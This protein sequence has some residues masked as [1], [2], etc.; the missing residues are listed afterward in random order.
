MVSRVT[1][2]RFEDDDF[3]DVARIL[4]KTWYTKAMTPGFGFLEA[5]YDLAY[6]LSISTYSHVALIDEHPCG[7]ILARGSKPH[8]RFTA[9]W[10]MATQDLER[11]LRMYDDE[12]TEKFL[13]RAATIR[14]N[15]SNMHEQ[16]GLPQ[17]NE[18][19]LLIVDPAAQNLGIGSLLLDTAS[20]YLINHDAT[21]A[22][23]Y[24]DIG[25]NW[26]FYERHN[27]KRMGTY[28]AT[29]TERREIPRELYLY[30]TKLSS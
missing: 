26:R 23:L 12:A 3:N 13:A 27:F 8:P 16:A 5:C 25:C 15:N 22:Y 21:Q 20:E 9:H 29:L 19:T 2:R 18:I 6:S 17:V 4:Q 14:R 24:T 7:I 30:G 10:N 28:R 1:Y 11:Q